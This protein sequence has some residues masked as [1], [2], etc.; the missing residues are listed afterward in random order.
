MHHAIT[1][2]LDTREGPENLG[3]CMP[4]NHHAVTIVLGAEAE[5]DHLGCH[6]HNTTIAQ[7]T[8]EEVN[9]PDLH[10]THT[11]T[12]MTKSRWGHHAS[13][14]GFAERRYPKDSNYTMISKSTTGPRTTIMVVRLSASSK[15]TRGARR[16]HQCK[17]YSYTS[18]AQHSHG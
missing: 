11:I 1:S 16:K 4:K 15:N 5:A 3:P 18:P 10:D 12:K 6:D 8:E 13:L 17:V 2:V 7:G 14:V 9:D